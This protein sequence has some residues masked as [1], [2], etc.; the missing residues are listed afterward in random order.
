MQPADRS[1][2]STSPGALVTW[3]DEADRVVPDARRCG[4]RRLPA[5]GRAVHGTGDQ[6]RGS[7]P[8]SGESGC[9]E[10][11][12]RIEPPLRA[13]EP[14]WRGV[15]RGVVC[16]SMPLTWDFAISSDGP[17]PPVTTPAVSLTHRLGAPARRGVTAREVEQVFANEP[18]WR[19]NKR[20]RAAQYAMDGR[21]DAGRPLR[22]LVTWADEAGRVLRAVT[23]WDREGR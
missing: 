14:H 10:R 21:T 1:T 19:R 16:R 18:T 11:V 23:A 13:W 15:S 9:M 22:V 3:T 2:R 6:A 4:R 7:P 12:R 8:T 20:G 5:R 17:C